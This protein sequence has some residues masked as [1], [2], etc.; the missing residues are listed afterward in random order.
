MWQPPVLW[1]DNLDAGS[2]KRAGPGGISVSGWTRSIT[3]LERR[4]DTC[5]IKTCIGE[6]SFTPGLRGLCVCVR[7]HVLSAY[8]R[9]ERTGCLIF[10]LEELKLSALEFGSWSVM[11][12]AKDINPSQLLIRPPLQADTHV[13]STTMTK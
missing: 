6:V 8:F 10:I 1:A 5:R 9:E 7:A 2:T 4:S 12:E 11:E 13:A 3:V